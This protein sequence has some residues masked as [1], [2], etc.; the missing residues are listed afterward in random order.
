[1]IPIRDERGRII[2][3]GGRI[4]SGDG[5]KYINSPETRFY[6]KSH[7]LYGFDLA[8]TAIQKADR[9]FVVEGYFDVLS[10]QQAGYLETVA[11]CG[12]ALTQEHLKRIRRM[13][14]NVI[15]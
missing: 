13:T 15:C 14:R 2:A 1:M 12:T 3:F 4:M 11:T 10:M 9:V 8:R 6:Q 7:T 5:P